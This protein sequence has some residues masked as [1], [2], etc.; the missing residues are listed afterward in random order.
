MTMESAKELKKMSNFGFGYVLLITN[1]KFYVLWVIICKSIHSSPPLLFCSKTFCQD[2]SLHLQLQSS[3]QT[4]FCNCRNTHQC[5]TVWVQSAVCLLHAS[6]EITIGCTHSIQQEECFSSRWGLIHLSTAQFT[7]KDSLLSQFSCKF[8][9]LSISFLPG[10]II[11]ITPRMDF[12]RLSLPLSS[13]VSFRA[14]FWPNR[15]RHDNKKRWRIGEK[16]KKKANWCGK[17]ASEEGIL[18]CCLNSPDLNFSLN[19]PQV[20]R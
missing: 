14:N 15:R 19:H 7:A 5:S 2:C 20:P 11:H 3:V 9:A 1:S 4:V 6:G 10:R 17:K 16:S 12:E 8:V 18:F 13:S